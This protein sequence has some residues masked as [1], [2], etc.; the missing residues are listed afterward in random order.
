MLGLLN[1]NPELLNGLV[2]GE[3]GKQYE[4]V[5]DDRVKLLKD[6]TPTTH[7]S[8]WNTGNNLIIWPEESVT[9]EMGKERDKSI[10]EAKDSPILGF[11]FV[12]DKVKT[13]I[14]NVATVMNRYAASLNTG[15][16]D[17]EETLPKLMDDL[18]TAGWDKVQKEMQTQL[19]EYIQSQK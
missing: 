1:S 9:E 17:P 18:K 3:E 13:E 5:G 19:D 16:V 14:T 12:N 7:L 10:E 4:K 8:A 15:T 11:T 6:Y 2:Y